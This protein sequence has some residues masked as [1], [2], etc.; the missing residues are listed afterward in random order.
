MVIGIGN[1]VQGVKVQSA[2][3]VVMSSPQGRKVRS[4]SPLEG[5]LKGGDFD[6]K[7]FPNKI[8][9]SHSK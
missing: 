3:C 1:E 7:T 9:I 8:Y 5:G 2:G 4:V 6:R